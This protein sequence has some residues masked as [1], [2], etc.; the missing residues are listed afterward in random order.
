[1]IIV[2]GSVLAK[3]ETFDEIKLLCVEH[4]LRSRAEP[5]CISHDVYVNVEEPLRLFFFEQWA[6]TATIE[7]HFAVP[8]SGQFVRDVRALAA[9]MTQIDVLEAEPVKP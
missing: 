7:A 5:G 6:D 4:V 8:A 9:E 3:A 2:T 1:M